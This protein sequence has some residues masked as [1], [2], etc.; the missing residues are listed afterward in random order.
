ATDGPRTT[1]TTCCGRLP[2][3]GEPLSL[4]VPKGADAPDF[5]EGFRRA[6]FGLTTNPSSSGEGGGRVSVGAMVSRDRF[7]APTGAEERPIGS[8]RKKRNPG[9]TP[10]GVRFSHNSD[11]ASG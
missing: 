4:E 11:T 7:P 2:V 8:C 9:V 5:Q 1:R 10:W 3:E 6:T